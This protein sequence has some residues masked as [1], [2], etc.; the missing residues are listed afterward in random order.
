MGKEKEKATLAESVALVVVVVAWLVICVRLGLSLPIPMLISWVIIYFFCR[1]TK[2]D[3]GST[4]NAMFEG[5]KN[6]FG[7]ITILFS[8]GML[9]GVWIA[10]GTIPTIIHMGLSIIS[11]KIFLLC[12]LII[13]SILSLATG[14]SYGSAGS[15]GIAMMGIGTA[16]G[17]P[18]GMVAGAAICGALFGD[19]M[20]PLSDTT[21]LCPSLVGADLFKHI[22]S[23]LY[24]TLPSYLLSIVFFTILGFKYGA[25]HYDASVIQSYIDG[26]ADH[27][28]ISPVTLIP[29]I[30]VIVLLICKRPAVPS[31]IIG[32]LAGMV[33]AIVVQ[34]CK[35]VDLIGIAYDGYYIESGIQLVDK[36]LNRGGLTSMSSVSYVMIFAVGLG[37]ALEH[38]GVISNLVGPIINKIKSIPQ[39]IGT[40][41]IVGFACSAVGCT[42]VMSHVLMGKIMGSVFKEKGVAPEVLSRTMEDCGTVGCVLLPWHTTP[43]YF[44]GVLG[45]TWLEFVPYVFMCYLTPIMAM[46]CALT[47]FG[48][49]MANKSEN[50]QEKLENE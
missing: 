18:P 9:V 20:S 36:L 44:C 3:Y 12:T 42:M 14:T 10:S 11:P 25:N 15:A 2:I 16:M 23:M 4:Q 19:K 39:L 31:I 45:V 50:E 21:N 37:V 24:T 33:C 28:T 13:C 26:L 30:I 49:F 47:G 41:L 43:V 48:I 46:V 5:I 7:S 8:V 35:F 40:T 17:I 29:M 38:L 32:A 6:A 27:F 1:I 22:K 34:G